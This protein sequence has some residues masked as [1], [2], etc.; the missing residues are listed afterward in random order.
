VTQFV[1]VYAN[2]QDSLDVRVSFGEYES[3]KIAC[4]D[5]QVDPETGDNLPENCIYQKEHDNGTRAMPCQYCPTDEDFEH[6]REDNYHYTIVM[7]VPKPGE[8]ASESRT[9]G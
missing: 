6:A 3:Y 8:H 5:N 4:F 2:S 7:E 1:I 9:N